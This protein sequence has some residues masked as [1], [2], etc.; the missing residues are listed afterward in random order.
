M[1]KQ[2]NKKIIFFESVMHEQNSA[3][4][5]LM[6][7]FQKWDK[8]NLFFMSTNDEIIKSR[9]Y[10]YKNFYHLGKK[11]YVHAFP[12][13]LFSKK[14]NHDESIETITNVKG[15]IYDNSL[16]KHKFSALASI[17]FFINRIIV[18]LNLDLIFH[19]CILSKDLENWINNIKPNYIYTTLSSRYS[20]LFMLAIHK[21]LKLPIVVHILDDWPT[22]IYNKG[23]FKVFL[24]R[25]IDKELIEL[26]SIATI[27]IGIS[28]Q[29]A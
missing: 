8:D 16:I 5:T 18:F 24:K 2:S 19:R 12:F 1:L 4:I 21:K 10:G 27:K 20:I 14:D 25:L 13:N 26:L 11:E 23:I 28:N 22:T 3:A 7:L 6:N 29:M 17:K 15:P 9:K